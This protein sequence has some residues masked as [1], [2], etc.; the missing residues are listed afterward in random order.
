MA[1]TANESPLG[2]GWEEKAEQRTDILGHHCP[3][4]QPC[5][6]LTALGTGQ[7]SKVPPASL[8]LGST[9][10]QVIDQTV[11]IHLP[12]PAA[13]LGLAGVPVLQSRASP[14][15]TGDHCQPPASAA[16][17]TILVWVLRLEPGSGCDACSCDSRQV[18][19]FF[20]PMFLACDTV[21]T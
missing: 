18:L 14:W 9:A 21:L 17:A 15:P 20:E 13:A 11:G 12:Q 10:S 1:L 8:H 19:G 16:E 7:H 2:R 4:L 3:P 5:S 6:V